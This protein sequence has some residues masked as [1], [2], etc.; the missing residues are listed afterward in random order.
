[1]RLPIRIVKSFWNLYIFVLLRV[2]HVI[3]ENKKIHHFCS[4]YYFFIFRAYVRQIHV[5]ED[6]KDTFEPKQCMSLVFDSL[7]YH[8]FS[9]IITRYA[10]VLRS[11]SKKFIDGC[12]ILI[13]SVTPKKGKD[14][15]ILWKRW[16]IALVISS[17]RVR[18]P[19]HF[20]LVLLCVYHE[21][22][23]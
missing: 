18:W 12:R 22:E 9:H 16:H 3:L 14:S 13:V 11:L 20:F 21:T 15:A 1:M 4:L 23:P 19:Q 6:G 10:F 2:L 5:W 7:K 8:A 17:K